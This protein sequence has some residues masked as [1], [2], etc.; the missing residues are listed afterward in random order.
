M[1]PV[2]SKPL[3]SGV[4]SKKHLYAI[5]FFSKSKKL[6]LELAKSFK[7]DLQRRISK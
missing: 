7:L 4:I 3:V 5:K 1:F 2:T 6:H